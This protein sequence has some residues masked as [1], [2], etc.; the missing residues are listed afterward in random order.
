MN[1][2]IFP[3]LLRFFA[4]FFL[5]AG[6]LL[7]AD[8]GEEAIQ[9][10]TDDYFAKRPNRTIGAGLTLDEARMAQRKFVA[11]LTPQLGARVGF[12]IALTSKAAQESAGASQ[13]VRGVLLQEMLLENTAKLSTNYG[14]HPIWEPDLLVV[15]KDAGINRAKTLLEVCAHLSEIIAFVELPDRIVADSQKVDGNLILAINGGAR[16]GV[17]GQRMKIDPSSE[18]VTALGEMA[19][20]ATDAHGVELVKADGRALLGHPLNP[21]LWLIQDLAKT[22]EKLKSGDLISLGSFAR[23]QDPVAGQHVTVRYVGLPAGE[24]RVSVEFVGREDGRTGGR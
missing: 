22:G 14:T 24:L 20:T 5:L 3:S 6:T 11:R 19:V 18:F 7:A 4:P 13:P 21:V 15:V 12:K 16:L 9:Q 10:L 17:M 2:K 8:L 23:P 1:S